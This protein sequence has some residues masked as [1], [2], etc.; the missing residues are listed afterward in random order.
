MGLWGRCPLALSPV[1]GAPLEGAFMQCLCRKHPKQLEV[2][3][4]VTVLPTLQQP[5]AASGSHADWN[6]DQDEQWHRGD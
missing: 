5:S 2:C 3:V 4:Q 1:T 6:S